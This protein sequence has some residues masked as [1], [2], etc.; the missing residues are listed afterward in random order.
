MNTLATIAS[1][2]CGPHWITAMIVYLA[3]ALVVFD[4]T[5]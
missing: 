1:T 4:L 2:L 3:L 5:R